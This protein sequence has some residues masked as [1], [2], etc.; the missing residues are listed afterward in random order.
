M[1]FQWFFQ[2]WRS[3]N[4]NFESIWDERFERIICWVRSPCLTSS[5]PQTALRA[6]L[7]HRAWP[8]SLSIFGERFPD[9]NFILKCLGF[10]SPSYGRDT[11]NQLI[12]QL[13]TITEVSIKIFRSAII[14]SYPIDYWLIQAWQARAPVD[15]QQ[16]SQLQRLPG[17]WKNHET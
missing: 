14:T 12:K 5:P 9:E 13:V 6:Q 15:G 3:D 16:W 8:G 2:R 10:L 4:S 17:G 1:S 7:E 11:V